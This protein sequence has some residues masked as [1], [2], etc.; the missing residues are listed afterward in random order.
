M[1]RKIT[2][3]L[4]AL[5][6]LAALAVPAFAA[7][8]TPAWHDKVDPWVLDQATGKRPV[9]FIVFLDQQADL[10]PARSISGKVAKG[11]WVSEALR[12]TAR[13]TQAPILERLDA[14]GVEHRSY[15][16][17]NMIWVQADREVVRQMAERADVRRVHANP[18]IRMEQPVE[19]TRD[20]VDAPESIEPGILNTEAPDVFWAAG[21]TGQSFVVAGADT[22]YDW[23]HPALKDHYRGWNGGSADHNFNWH[24]S[25]H[26]GGGSC[27]ADSPQPC[28]DDIH[29]THTMGTMVGDDGGSNQIGMAPGAKWMGCRNMNQGFGSPTSYTECFE[30]F[31]APT[32]LSGNNPDPSKAPHVINNSWTCPGFEG[33]TD[34]NVLKQV[35]EN[36]RA[37]GIVVVASAGN[38]GSGCST[39]SDPPAI[40]DASFSV[41]ATDNSDNIASFSSRGPVTADGSNRLKP[42]ISAPGVSVRSSIPGTGYT[43]LSGTSMA[44]PHVVGMVAL[45]LS[46]APCLEGDVDAIEQYIID[47]ALPRTSTQTCGGVPGSEIPNNTY[48]WGAIRSALPGGLCGG[49]ISGT[50]SGVDARRALCR[51]LETGAQV[52]IDLGGVGAW[53]CAGLFYGPGDL[54]GTGIAGLADGAAAVGGSVAGMTATSVACENRSTGDSVSFAPGGS[55]WDCEAQGLVVS[56]GDQILQKVQGAAN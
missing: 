19:I 31:M 49:G 10:S 53:E 45:V 39:V 16:V 44:G 46:A 30:F 15:W 37:A 18:W 17:A 36:T 22:G 35:V 12:E 13:R 25:I 24:D 40:Y 26:S 50:G 3:K 56:V 55:S 41:G 33:C 21:F 23:D 9:E 52:V 6:A 7:G 28:D 20:R 11:A 29:G 47:A 8:I 5:V 4:L 27:G 2:P 34:K 38:A 48:G 1:L 54:I 51:N 14:L 42:D 43:F 32:D